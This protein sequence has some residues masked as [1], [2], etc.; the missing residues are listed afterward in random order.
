MSKL[1]LNFATKVSNMIT[2]KS[3][4]NGANN[5]QRAMV[6]GAVNTNQVK[7]DKSVF[8]KTASEKEELRIEKAH[9]KKINSL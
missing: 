7:I 1:K 3:D 5:A 2:V 9:W 8:V 6:Q 4:N